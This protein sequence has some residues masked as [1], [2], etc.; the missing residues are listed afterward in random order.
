MSN[1]FLFFRVGTK[2]TG[3]RFLTFVDSV[4]GYHHLLQQADLD[5]ALSLCT[6]M[7]LMLRR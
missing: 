4:H 5:R 2:E 3:T 6:G 7:R 1:N